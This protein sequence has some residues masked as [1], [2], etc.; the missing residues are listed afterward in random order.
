MTLIATESDA[1]RTTEPMVSPKN[2]SS[3][4]AAEMNR[5]R[6]MILGDTSSRVD[7]IS[8]LV[9]SRDSRVR[10]LVEDIP[11]AI[12]KS[13]ADQ[14]ALT[15]LATSL[16]MP[17]ELALSQ[18]V[19]NDQQKVADILAPALARALPKT[20]ANFILSLP[21]NLLNRVWR[22]IWPWA[23]KSEEYASGS[24]KGPSPGSGI[25]VDRVCLFQKGTLAVLRSSD[26][27][28]ED[29]ATG[30]EVDHLFVQ[31]MDELRNGSPSPTATLRYP[32]TKS[33]T[34]SQHM[35]VLEGE[36]TL[37]AAYYI[38][39]P[40]AWFRDRMQ[41]LADDA[42]ALGHT[43]L[44]LSASKQP[45]ETQ[46]ESLDDLLKKAL[47]CFVPPTGPK[48]A[49]STVRA[50]SWFMDAFVVAA[51]IGIVWMVSFLSRS[52]TQW[53]Q[54][55][56][57]LDA[58]PGIVVLGQSWLPG[59]SITGLRD[60]LAPEPKGILDS[61]GYPS[62][63]VKLAFTP[64]LSD[65]AP[66]REQRLSLQRAERDSVKRE[67][68]TAYARTLA[69]MEATLD[70]PANPDAASES[71]RSALRKELLR[72]ILELPPETPFEYRDGVI[73]LPN[74]LPKVTHDR[75]Q[76][77]LKLVPWIKQI[78]KADLKAKTTSGLMPWEHAP[79]A[80]SEVAAVEPL[81][82]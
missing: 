51:V 1:Q 27:G 23:A 68:S 22:V 28:F 70:A 10:R 75:I 12:T 35:L 60:P 57:Q 58:E 6:E 73:T 3:K 36:H 41:G 61:L 25:R 4:S 18:S 74:Q 81:S 42:D 24:H 2:P 72:S 37:F 13:T 78:I 5:L 20:L 76:E 79:A 39:Q 63:G 30:L 54:A 7:D 50:T 82:P 80:Q 44:S 53:Q 34:D 67:I 59:G 31:L 40:P 8:R 77:T 52:S 26:M 38:G 17:V 43:L 48:S 21:G 49:G 69:L 16:Q 32:R 11:E 56:R 19:K 71:G 9:T 46:L 65:D 33:K 62:K 47:I 15:R 64:F 45:M 66:Y 55:V 14:S 29:E